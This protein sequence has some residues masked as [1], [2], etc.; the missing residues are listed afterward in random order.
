LLGRYGAAA[1]ELIERASGQDL[2]DIG[3]S[4]VCRAELDWSLRHEGVAHL[5]DL[6][7]RRSRFGLLLPDGGE[8]WLPQLESLCGESCGWDRSRWSSECERYLDIV[9]RNY[10]VPN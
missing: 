9:A 10:S 5:D 1:V 2:V 4:G 3:G 8:H 6:L 7:L